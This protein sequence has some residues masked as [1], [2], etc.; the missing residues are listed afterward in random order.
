MKGSMT[1]GGPLLTIS[2]SPD[3]GIRTLVLINHLNHPQQIL[4]LQLLQPIGNLLV[5]KLLARLLRA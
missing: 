5:V 1:G 2:V 4:F 3:I